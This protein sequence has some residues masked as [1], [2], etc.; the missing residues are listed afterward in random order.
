MHTLIETF[1]ILAEAK[2]AAMKVIIDRITEKKL[3][4]I[5]KGELKAISAFEW[6]QN[7]FGFEFCKSLKVGVKGVEGMERGPNGEK[8]VYFYVRN[9]QLSWNGLLWV[10]VEFPAY[11]TWLVSKTLHFNSERRKF[12]DID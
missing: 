5:D 6:K 2:K 3:I 1:E 7:D 8:D 11:P 4:I 9:L 10:D 12:E